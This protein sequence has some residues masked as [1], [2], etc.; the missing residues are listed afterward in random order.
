VLLLASADAHAVTCTYACLPA[1]LR[2]RL[3]DRPA[4]EDKNWHQSELPT[5]SFLAASD[6]ANLL[7]T[8][9]LGLQSTVQCMH[10][11]LH[12]HLHLHLAC[13]CTRT[14]CCALPARLLLSMGPCY[15]LAAEDKNW[16]QSELPTTHSWQHL[17][18][19]TCYTL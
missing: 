19:Q 15:L 5:Y 18:M 1:C 13:T 6:D 8:L 10:L 2:A 7:H 12:L 17:T 16:H 4:A 3:P 11:L 9:R 14:S